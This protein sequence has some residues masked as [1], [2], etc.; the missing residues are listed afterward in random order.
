MWVTLMIVEESIG[1]RLPCGIVTYRDIVVSLVAKGLDPDTLKVGEVAGSELV[2]A[3]E[4]DGVSEII[5]LMRVKAVRRLPIVDAQGG[6]VGIITADDIVDLLAEEMTALWPK[7]SRGN[8]GPKPSCA[9]SSSIM[10]R[11]SVIDSL[12]SWRQSAGLLNVA[13]PY[14]MPSPINRKLGLLQ[15]VRPDPHRDLVR[16]LLDPVCYPHPAHKV[17]HIETH[18]SDVFLTGDYAYKLKKPLNLGFLDFSTLEKRRFFCEEELRLNRRLAPELYLD[19]VPITGEPGHPRIGGDGEPID[20]AVRMRQFDQAGMLEHVLDRGQLTGAH[21]D[22]IADLVAGF[23]TALP[24][25]PD[26]SQYGSPKSIIGPALQN[27]DQLSPLLESEQDRAVLE[28]LR[29]WT[30]AQHANLANVLEGRRRGGFVRECHGDLHLGNIVLIDGRVRIF[31]CI[32]FNPDLRWIDVISE[33]AFLAMDLAQRQHRDLAFRFLNRYLEV[34]GDYAGVHLLRYYMVYRALV[35]AKVA[36]MRAAQHDVERAA[37]P[38]LRAKCSAHLT[39]AE[40]MIEAARPALVILHGLSGSGKTSVSQIA[41]E[42]VGAIRIRSDIERKRLHGF[43]GGARSAS[44]VGEGIYTEAAGT[45]TYNHLIQLTSYVLEGELPVLV[46]AT[47]LEIAQRE[48]FRS[49]ADEHRVPFAIL[50]IEASG[51]ELRRRI[52][53]RARAGADASEATIA[54]LDRQ[55]QTQDAL[56]SEERAWTIDTEHMDQ[57]EI[58][59]QSRQLL[60][61]LTGARDLRNVW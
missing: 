34:T 24:P 51:P 6:L 53:R 12:G 43:S 36:L 30:S 3:R 23:H 21:M 19:V 17:E 13:D 57:R 42:S 31:D 18:I 15:Q 27:F 48:R 60:Q 35:R 33:A 1:R 9:L 28:R 22:E 2:T 16:S 11:R 4:T 38:R 56:R 45:A 52:A 41:L 59:E 25:A 14:N 5:E 10:S 7:W 39:L 8:H 32:E 20:Y 44:A 58:A 54:V 46:D 50:H 49:L 40:Q 55:L 29:Q 61:Q 26:S 37:I 47:F